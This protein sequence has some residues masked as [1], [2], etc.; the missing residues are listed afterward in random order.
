MP[1]YKTHSIYC[2]EVLNNMEIPFETDKEEVKSFAFGPD[3]ILF[4]NYNLFQY[5]HK[6]K[7][8]EY[9]ETFPKLIKD[10]KLEDNRQAVTGYYCNV[11]HLI[12]DSKV[13][14][15]I[16]FFTAGLRPKHRIDVH[17]YNEMQLDNYVMKL[18]NKLDKDYYKKQIL[19]NKDY[20]KILND[21]YK[22]VFYV[23]NI[24]PQFELGM[25]IIKAY[26]SVIRKHNIALFRGISKLL[27]TGNI[28]YNSDLSEIKKML[29]LEHKKIYNPYTGTPSTKSFDDIWKESIEAGK[30]AIEDINKY[31]YKGKPLNNYYIKN[32]ISYNTGMPCKKRAK[33]LC[34]KKYK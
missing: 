8:R 3:A 29:N 9:F 13:H 21:L 11:L 2:E 23:D 17:S 1:N 15:M 12:L 27:N 32:D 24:A 26:D 30:N 25:F 33:I 28:F 22:K 16:D 14:P 19:L 31:L 10:N 5:Q 4:T 18:T 34:F 6:A 20:K 7:T